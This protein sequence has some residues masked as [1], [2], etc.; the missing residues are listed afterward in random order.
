[1]I[2]CIHSTYLTE[3]AILTCEDWLFVS[4]SQVPESHWNQ[5]DWSRSS[6]GLS[7]HGMFQRQWRK[8][9][10]AM[11]FQCHSFLLYFMHRA[12]SWDTLEPILSRS[13]TIRT[14]FR[15]LYLPLSTA[16]A[17]SQRISKLTSIPRVPQFRLYP[18]PYSWGHY[19]HAEVNGYFLCLER[20]VFLLQNLSIT[21]RKKAWEW[22]GVETRSLY[23]DGDGLCLEPRNQYI[24]TVSP[25]LS[26]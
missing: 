1:L 17:L 11:R 23:F 18:I 24:A 13:S 14:L 19:R 10:I 8:S 15:F 25:C 5:S 21:S 22:K 9:T 12:N 7:I 26:T 4:G 20:E 16:S 6:D 3:D 2:L